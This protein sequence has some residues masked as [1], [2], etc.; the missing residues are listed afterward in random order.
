MAHAAHCDLAGNTLL[1]II[2]KDSNFKDFYI[3]YYTDPHLFIT[4]IKMFFVVELI[5]P[6]TSVIIGVGKGCKTFF[7]C[8][9]HTF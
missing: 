6:A 2:S 7:K 5:L 1:I 3:G 8:F 9:Q 4:I